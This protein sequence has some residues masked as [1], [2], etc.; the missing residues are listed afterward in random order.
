M[1]LRD[2]VVAVGLLIQVNRIYQ[3]RQSDDRQQ[4][5]GDSDVHL[6]MP[7]SSPKKL[8]ADSRLSTQVMQ[9][10]ANNR[11]GHD[12]IE[13]RND[14]A[15]SIPCIWCKCSACVVDQMVPTSR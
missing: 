4:E 15:R 14:T 10:F 5:A 1:A 12:T 2:E 9:T 8:I 11:T 6:T 13:P 3:G 7:P